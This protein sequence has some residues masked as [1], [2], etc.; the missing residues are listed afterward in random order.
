MAQLVNRPIEFVGKN[1][2]HA[3]AKSHW[4]QEGS[5]L[6]A[7]YDRPWDTHHTDIQFF[8]GYAS[9]VQSASSERRW[10]SR[11]TPDAYPGYVQRNNDRVF[12]YAQNVDIEPYGVPTDKVMTALGGVARYEF[13]R[14]TVR[15]ETLPYN[16]WT[17]DQ[18]RHNGWV[19]ENGNPHDCANGYP[20]RFISRVAKLKGVLVSV[21]RGAMRFAEGSRGPRVV[22]GVE[23]VGDPYQASPGVGQATQQVTLIHHQVPVD[24]IPSR[25]WNP[26][27]TSTDEAAL[28][29]YVNTMNKTAFLGQ[30]PGTVLYLGG[31][32]RAKRNPYGE[33]VFDIELA[34]DIFV[35]GQHRVPT[36]SA[37][38]STEPADSPPQFEYV[39]VSTDGKYKAPGSVPDGT[40]IY[41][42]RE[43]SD[44]FR[45]PI[46]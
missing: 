28:D 5:T 36:V 10:I 25:T 19:D 6:T 11:R 18:M 39:Q 43:L 12:L 3:S 24:A 14:F 42:E 35:K 23:V 27:L 4:T 31:D 26:N 9:V 2:P 33:R 34:F 21:S 8:L 45:P 20:T 22:S 29:D 46:Y 17:D 16:V 30:P 38:S 13:A 32:V 41:N 1:A 15:Y 40:L 44:L 7:V 37:A